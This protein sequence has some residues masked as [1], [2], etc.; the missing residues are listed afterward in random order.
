MKRFLLFAWVFL[1]LGM[2]YAQTEVNILA[3]MDDPRVMGMTSTFFVSPSEGWMFGTDARIFYTA[4]GG[5]TWLE[6][7]YVA[8]ADTT[9]RDAYFIDNMTGWLVGDDGIIWKTTDG[10]DVWISQTSAV[11]TETLYS[12]YA[13]DANTVYASGGASSYGIVLKTTDGGLIWDLVVDGAPKY[14]YAIY[15]FDA[16]RAFA[17][18]GG[19][20]GAVH[21]YDADSLKWVSQPLPVPPLAASARQY[22]CSGSPDGVGYSFGYSGAVYKTSDYAKT[23]E[24]VGVLNGGFEQF[25]CGNAIDADNVWAGGSNGMLCYSQNGGASWDTLSFPSKTTIEN[26][27]VFDVNTFNVFADY[28]QAFSTTDGGLN[29]TPIFTWPSVSYY[30]IEAINANDIIAVTY[31]GGDVTR[32]N[33]GGQTWSYP[34]NTTKASSVKDVTFVDDNVG[35]FVAADGYIGKS[36]DG[37]ASWEL[38]DNS[39]F[40]VSNK[41]YHFVFF[42]DALNG[43]AGGSSGALQFTHDGGET[44]TEGYAEASFTIYDGMYLNDSTGFAVGSSGKICKTTKGDTGWAEVIDF[45]TMNMRNIV[46]VNETTGFIVSSNGFIFKTTDAGDSWVAADTLENLNA[47]DD[48]PDLYAISFVNESTGFICGEDGAFYMTEDM[49]ESWEQISVPDDLLTNTLQGMDWVNETTGFIVGQDGIIIG[50]E[51]VTSIDD[52]KSI[53]PVSVKLYPNYPNPFNPTTTIEY[54]LELA[55]S[56]ELVIYDIQGRKV[57][58]LV[59]SSQRA[60][61]HKSTWDG[62]N[63]MGARVSSGVYVYSLKVNSMAQTRKMILIK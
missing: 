43:F 52:P 29:F 6:Q 15:A 35:F 2:V 9:F 50:V 32:S 45:G 49:G 44:W 19:T 55:G 5:D 27:N 38:K 17:V 40:G 56:V 58:T 34:I 51:I 36:T 24:N 46:F 28:N 30:A 59:N 16:D 54:E 63:E 62:R 22:D 20:D 42:K 14:L 3:E 33:D 60:G 25:R 47:I 18:S 26:I 53:R 57:R 10:G 21:Y 1:S 13:V 41:Y 37:G 23:W 31:Q 61:S 11:T 39:L 48:V 4:D 8:G 12:V 7:S